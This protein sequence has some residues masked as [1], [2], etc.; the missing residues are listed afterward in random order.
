MK[1]GDGVQVAT[2]AVEEYSIAADAWVQR[3]PLNSPRSHFGA[4]YLDSQI[5][6]FGGQAICTS[7]T[8]CLNECAPPS[9][10]THLSNWPCI[11]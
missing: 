10:L 2:R 8:M 11:T 6:V 5:I 4:A 9:S 7:E 1:S 3:A